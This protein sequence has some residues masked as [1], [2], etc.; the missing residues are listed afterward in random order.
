M[1]SN[2]DTGWASPAAAAALQPAPATRDP[3]FMLRVLDEMDY[4]LVVV[5]AQLGILHC[6]HL[7]RQE[8]GCARML[9]SHGQFLMG[10][11][12]EI[13][14]QLEAAVG[15]ACRGQR[16]LEVFHR[17]D[18][19][20]AASFIPL[21]HPLEPTAPQVLVTLERQ[22]VCDNLAVRMFARGQGLSPGEE[23]VLIALCRGL[24]IH[25]IAQEHGVA[26]STVR[27][28]VKAVRAKTGSGSIR[29]LLARIN[30]LPP[31][32]PAL[33][34]IAPV[35]HNSRESSPS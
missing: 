10:S 25:S 4:G 19:A 8:L 18:Q 34:I 24:S 23:L 3:A 7:A 30:R 6:N 9:V 20:L 1:W 11:T 22:S 15:L 14:S 16:R 13:A 21:S 33:R 26:E 17:G 5:N 12:L 35:Q 28:Q 31:V 27:T 29:Q 2:Q 32:V